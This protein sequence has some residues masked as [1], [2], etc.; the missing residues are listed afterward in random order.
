MFQHPKYNPLSHQTHP[1]KPLYYV[2]TIPT[3]LE[4]FHHISSNSCC[5]NLISTHLL[6]PLNNSW[7]TGL[8]APILR[9]FLLKY[10]YADKLNSLTV[11]YLVQVLWVHYTRYECT[12]TT[13]YPCSDIL[14]YYTFHT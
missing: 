7:F 3:N 4:S 8:K 13:T 9:H 12:P 2:S 5:L 10:I 14:G 11:L 1:Y 6:P